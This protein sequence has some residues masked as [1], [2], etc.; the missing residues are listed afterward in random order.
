[1]FPN[2]G[3]RMKIINLVILNVLTLTCAAQVRPPAPT[4]P[5]IISSGTTPAARPPGVSVPG[6]AP[7]H[8]A[9]APQAALSAASRIQSGNFGV[10]DVHELLIDLQG[11]L[12]QAQSLLSALTSGSGGIDPTTGLPKQLVA[13]AVQGQNGAA[14]VGVAGTNRVAINAETYNL[15]VVLQQS[16]GQ[17]LVNLQDLN[18]PGA[19]TSQHVGAPNRS[20]LLNRV[21]ILSPKVGPSSAPAVIPANPVQRRPALQPAMPASPP[22]GSAQ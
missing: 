21:N 3:V 5:T 2:W 8:S 20:G 15:L 19:V 4:N 11:S 9:V 18:G 17:T 6:L 16:M 10:A 7:N 12:E 13:S 14:F 22:G 1:M